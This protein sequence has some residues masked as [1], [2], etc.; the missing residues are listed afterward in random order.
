MSHYKVNDD[1][2][3]FEWNPESDPQPDNS[4]QSI[5]Y[6]RQLNNQL[7]SNSDLGVSAKE[8]H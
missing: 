5:V 4:Q 8:E 6:V 2:L 7:K 3:L 1:K